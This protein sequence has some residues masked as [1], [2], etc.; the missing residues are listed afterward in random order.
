M[1]LGGRLTRERL[2]VVDFEREVHE[3]GLHHHRGSA[4][5]HLAEFDFLLAVRGLEE[6]QLRAARGG[7]P[8]RDLQA[9]DLLVET[10]AAFDVVHAHPRV[11]KFFD[12]HAPDC[13][14]A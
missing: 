14:A 12:A 11:E 9:D 4:R 13:G 1:P 7:V 8:T 10:H 6:D 3:I 2:E 5:G